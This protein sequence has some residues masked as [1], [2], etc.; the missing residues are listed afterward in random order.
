M[1]CFVIN[2]CFVGGFEFPTTSFF[3]TTDGFPI[4]FFNQ[5]IVSFV[6]ANYSVG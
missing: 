4:A 2:D 5:T 1:V 3:V 6:A